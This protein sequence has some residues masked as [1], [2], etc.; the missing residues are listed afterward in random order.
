MTLSKSLIE[1]CFRGLPFQKERTEQKT[2]CL[3]E[4]SLLAF[5][6]FQINFKVFRYAK[7]RASWQQHQPC[8]WPETCVDFCM[9]EKKEIF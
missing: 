7:G 1:L 2:Q 5:I 3:T 8:A 6:K 4:V 9:F